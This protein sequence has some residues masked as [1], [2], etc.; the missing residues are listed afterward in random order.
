VVRGAGI[1]P[2]TDSAPDCSGIAP[3]RTYVGAELSQIKGS[4]SSFEREVSG[5]NCTVTLSFGTLDPAAIADVASCALDTEVQ[6]TVD[7][8]NVTVRPTGD[9]RLCD[10]VV[11]NTRIDIHSQ[12]VG[13]RGPTAKM[14]MPHRAIDARIIGYDTI[15]YP[16]FIVSAQLDY[17]YDYGDV[18]NGVFGQFYTDDYWWYNTFQTLGSTYGSDGMGTTWYTRYYYAHEYSNGF[19]NSTFPDTEAWVQPTAYGY[20]NGN[21]SCG[22]YYVWGNPYPDVAWTLSCAHN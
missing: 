8:V 7:A 18:Y 20:S 5:A 11:A 4:S 10:G 14:V 9:A 22:Y 19:P 3:I 15:Y 17:D 6:A 12:A 21:Y 13:F 2:L 16:M 1:P